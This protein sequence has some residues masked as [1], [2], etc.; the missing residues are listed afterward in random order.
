M[1]FVDDIIDFPNN[2]DKLKKWSLYGLLILLCLLFAMMVWYVLR[3]NKSGGE[4]G[5]DPLM[6]LLHLIGYIVFAVVVCLALFGIFCVSKSQFILWHLIGCLALLCAEGF[7]MAWNAVA[8]SKLIPKS[9]ALP[10][11]I[12]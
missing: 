12:I 3:Y 9:L 11:V 5:I 2:E 6:S 10:L 8:S 4:S 1:G 7:C